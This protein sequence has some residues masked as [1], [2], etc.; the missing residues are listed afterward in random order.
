MK[1]VIHDWNDEDARRI[2]GNS[3]KVTPRD[4]A[5]LLVEWDLS[6]ANLPSRA[7]F[8]DVT[9][10]VLTGGKERTIE[11]YRTLLG[12]VGFRLNR[13]IPTGAVNLIEVLPI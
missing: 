8:A 12:G 1:S 13:V 4:G 10:M 2:L 3:R 5:L 6:E 11:E 9:M 7:K